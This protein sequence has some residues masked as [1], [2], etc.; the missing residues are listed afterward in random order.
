[1]SFTRKL[2]GNAVPLTR[3][4]QA[5]VPG[6]HARSDRIQAPIRLRMADTLMPSAEMSQAAEDGPCK[7]CRHFER[8]TVERICCEGLRAVR[9]PGR[10]L[11]RRELDPRTT[12]AQ[13]RHLRAAS[14][15]IAAA[16]R[17]GAP[18][19]A[20]GAGDQDAARGGGVLTQ[21]CGNWILSRAS[22]TRTICSDIHSGV[23][24]TFAVT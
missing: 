5:Q 15:G 2:H 10:G 23:I 4:P 13:C 19:G 21:D 17:R 16:D 12:S 6:L 24:S 22:L 7:G 3:H 18:A 20:R 1:M 14:R 8:C 9:S 11:R